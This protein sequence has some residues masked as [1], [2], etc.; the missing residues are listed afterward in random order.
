MGRTACE[1]CQRQRGRRD[2]KIA[3]AGV[4]C[5]KQPP[6]APPQPPSGP[7]PGEST[8]RVPPPALLCTALWAYGPAVYVSRGQGS[9]EH[10]PRTSCNAAYPGVWEQGLDRHP[11]V[12]PQGSVKECLGRPALPGSPPMA[13]RVQQGSSAPGAW[14]YGKNA[15][16]AT[17][18]VPSSPG[19]LSV[20]LPCPTVRA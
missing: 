10:A 12:T 13:L 15:L 16:T 9:A 11:P 4:V 18:S 1:A 2:S 20:G 8:L 19:G 14:E 3:L 6:T 7:L 17:T 5:T